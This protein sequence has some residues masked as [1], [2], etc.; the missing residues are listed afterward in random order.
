[1]RLPA[2]HT[3]PWPLPVSI[4]AIVLAAMQKIALD[5]H[6]IDSR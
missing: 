3:G 2:D 1:M 4:I 5:A 6:V